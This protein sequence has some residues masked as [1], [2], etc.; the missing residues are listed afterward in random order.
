MNKQSVKI[1]LNF[2]LLACLALKGWGETFIMP[3][4]SCQREL[5]VTRHYEI[6]V[7]KGSAAV[8]AVPIKDTIKRVKAGCIVETVPREALY[9]AQTPQGFRREIIEKAYRRHV[10]TDSTDDALLV[11]LS[12]AKVAFVES[13]YDNFKITTPE[14]LRIARA[15]ISLPE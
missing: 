2:I 7:Q 5:Q 3:V 6:A 11:E 8:A 12:G 10:D 14:D 9:A 4:K 15:I 13:T 1:M